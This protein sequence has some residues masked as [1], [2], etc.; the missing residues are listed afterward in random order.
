MAEAAGTQQK[1][2]A[3]FER[4]G[5]TV[6]LIRD[7]EHWSVLTR[8]KQATLGALVLLAHGEERA[9]A[10]LPPAAFAELAGITKDI[11]ATARRLFSF[12]KINYLM[13]MMV[14][15]HVHFHVLPRYQAAREFAGIAFADSGWPGPPDLAG[16]PAE[17]EAATRVC[18][19]LRDAWPQ[20]TAAG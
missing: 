11:E 20:R 8:P 3:T 18:A 16:G 4:F 17:A 5:G 10:D 14:D 2:N 13:L 15:P 19:A 9:F 7:Y 6:T 12:D 1:R